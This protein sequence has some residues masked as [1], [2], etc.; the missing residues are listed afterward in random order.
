MLIN[1]VRPGP[2]P[3]PGLPPEIFGPDGRAYRVIFEK[4]VECATRRT[5]KTRKSISFLRSDYQIRIK[6]CH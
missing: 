3:G 6:K 5:Q 4:F 1:R 2:G